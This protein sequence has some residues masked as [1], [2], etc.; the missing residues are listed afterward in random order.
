MRRY[1]LFGYDVHYAGGGLY[2]NMG[3]VDDISSCDPRSLVEWKCYQA[4]DLETGNGYE[5]EVG[6]DDQGKWV[7]NWN[8][9]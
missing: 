8:I 7:H 1:L 6:K 2:D 9:S 4:L 5:Y 3:T